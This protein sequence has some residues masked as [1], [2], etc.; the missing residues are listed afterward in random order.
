MRKPNTTNVPLDVIFFPQQNGAMRKP[1][2]NN[3]GL[4]YAKGQGVHKDKTEAAKGYSK[5]AKQGQEDARAALKEM[6]KQR[7]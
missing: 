2:T 3:L 6:G 4:M 1:N 7:P 5:A